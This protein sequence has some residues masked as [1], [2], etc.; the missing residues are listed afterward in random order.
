M[1]SSSRIAPG[2]VICLSSIFVA[3]LV[4]IAWFAYCEVEK[5]RV[6]AQADPE[7]YRQAMIAREELK[8]RASEI[9]L[10][11][12]EQ[13]LAEEARSRPKS[14]ETTPATSQPARW[15]LH[16]ADNKR[17]PVAV[18]KEEYDEFLKFS[19]AQDMQGVTGMLVAGQVF[20]VDSGTPV[21][22]LGGVLTCEVRILDGP[23][24]GTVGWVAGDFME[25]K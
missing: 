15:V 6:W 22:R 20:M 25:R 12:R 4:C 9:R 7:G 2:V 24:R 19:S 23:H 8:Q 11:E 17:V 13:Q 3:M 5:E 10:R 21:V 18:S 14:A 1:K 16:T